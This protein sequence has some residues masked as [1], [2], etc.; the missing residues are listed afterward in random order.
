[1]TGYGAARRREGDFLVEAEVRSVNN[2]F[3]KINFRAPEVFLPA[4]MELEETVKQKLSRGTVDLTLRIQSGEAGGVA[5]HVAVL[6]RYRKQFEEIQKRLQIPGTVEMAWLASLPGVVGDA[7]E[8][9]DEGEAH[10]L[11]GLALEATREAL[12][13]LGQ[14]RRAEGQAQ[15]TE[16]LALMDEITKLSQSIE[17]R[18]PAVLAEYQQRLRTRVQE[19]LHDSGI[20][21]A[22]DDLLRELAI[23]AERSDI[24]EET[25]RLKSHVAQFREACGRTE[26]VGRKLEFIAQEMHRE[27]NTIG[28]KANDAALSVLIVE[29]KGV[30]ERVREQVMNVE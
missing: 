23:F 17:S 28:S 26:P 3:L 24:A 5:I 10:R 25:Q 12:E 18:R 14:M 2:R 4:Q 8:V 30:I 20:S 11:T 15:E 27:V 22:E 6:E 7:A 21:V 1:M 13:V 19:L 16:F 9:E 29:L